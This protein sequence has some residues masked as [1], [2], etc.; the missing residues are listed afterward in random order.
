MSVDGKSKV[1]H[2]CPSPGTLMPLVHAHKVDD[3]PFELKLLNWPLDYPRW[4]ELYFALLGLSYGNMPNVSTKMEYNFNI[5]IF[6]AQ[7]INT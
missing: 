6:F 3:P 7:I 1:P 2:I 4:L 5:D